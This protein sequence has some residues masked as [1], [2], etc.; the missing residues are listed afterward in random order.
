MS[1]LVDP[2][3]G[4]AWQH[5]GPRTGFEVCWFALGG[6]GVVIDGTTAAVEDG[7]AWTVEY[8]IGLDRTWATE[9]ARVRTRSVAGERTTELAVVEP[10]RW[11]VDGRPAPQLDGCLDVDLEA[12]AMTNA[13]PIHRL[14][15]EVGAEA[16]APAAYVRVTPDAV[17]RLE[18]V[19]V[20]RADRSGRRRYDY[21]APA[22]GF[23]CRLEYDRHGLILDYPGIARRV[24]G[25]DL[26]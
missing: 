16:A 25:A 8:A 14:G 23:A 24:A 20:R 26:L 3:P 19:Y 7:A 4:A 11:T 21:A 15:F 5:V 17:E 2:P 18:Q 6:A 13:L 12:S 9:W 10:G 1:D 22:F